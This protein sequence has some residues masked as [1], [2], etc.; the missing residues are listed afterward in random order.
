MSCDW[1]CVQLLNKQAPQARML[2]AGSQSSCQGF[3]TAQACSA[4]S[5]VGK[6]GCRLWGQ[7]SGR[8]PDVL[9]SCPLQAS[10]RPSE[11][12]NKAEAGRTVVLVKSRP[13]GGGGGS[14]GKGSAAK[15]GKGAASEGA[16]GE[17]EGSKGAARQVSTLWGRSQVAAMQNVRMSLTPTEGAKQGQQQGCWLQGLLAAAALAG[18][19]QDSPNCVAQL[20][21]PAP[22]H[23][24][25]D[26]TCP[27]CDCRASSFL[28]AHPLHML[29][30]SAFCIVFVL[31]NRMLSGVLAV[32]KL[33]QTDLRS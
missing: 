17:A 21:V 31:V 2:S 20:D 15:A 3:Q 24:L 27:G 12:S 13:P 6:T 28:P 9:H 1:R 33:R 4:T 16:P 10:A 30:N 26:G 11:S 23:V 7:S 25:H 32:P 5:R 14:S 18:V 19:P 22:I 29:F 8:R